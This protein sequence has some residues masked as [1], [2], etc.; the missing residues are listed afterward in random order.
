MVGIVLYFITLQAYMYHCY[1]TESW[2]I[3][4]K[5]T[6]K[7]INQINKYTHTHTHTLNRFFK[8]P[9]KYH[10]SSWWWRHHLLPGIC[11]TCYIFNS[12]RISRL[13]IFKPTI[14]YSFLASYFANCHFK[15]TC[16][17][18]FVKNRKFIRWYSLNNE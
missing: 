14:I 10:K 5:N 9:E 4:N 3:R 6:H 15:S 16:S 13:S 12:N 8:N 7:I 2:N 1:S 17:K 18:N 11:W